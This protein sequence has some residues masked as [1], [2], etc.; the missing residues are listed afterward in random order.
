MF[1]PR[2]TMPEKG[3]P[4]Y[5]RKQ[6]GGYS[7]AIQPNGSNG[8]VE[9]LNVLPNCVGYGFGRFNEIAGQG[10]MIYLAPVN[11]ELFID[12]KDYR[13][14]G[15][16]VGLTPKLGACMVWQA[17]A[18][19]DGKDGAGHVAIVEQINPDGSIVTSESGWNDKRIF[20][21]RT[22]YYG[23]GNWGQGSNYKFLGFIY[24]PSVVKDYTLTLE[25][26]T[27]K[28]MKDAKEAFKLLGF[29]FKD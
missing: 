14:K 2:L 13:T 29:K 9:G 10:K 17:G 5:N 7:D 21:T 15:L 12:Y 4:Y 1:K 22:R 27:E 25:F 3:N 19:K 26:H 8:C 18:T 11:A 16:Q 23:D 20:W 24:N 28:E 6:N